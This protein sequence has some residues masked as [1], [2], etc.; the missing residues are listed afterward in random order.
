LCGLKPIFAELARLNL[1]SLTHVNLPPI[2]LST[3]Q[4]ALGDEVPGMAAGRSAPSGSGEV[5]A[6]TLRPAAAFAASLGFAALQLSVTAAGLRPRDLDRSARRDLAGMLRRSGL[7]LSGVD[8]FVPP[9]H[10]VLPAF[11]DRAVAALVAAA[12]TSRELADLCAGTPS[13]PRD[14]AS[15]GASVTFFAHPS[16]SAEVLTTIA[17]AGDRHGVRFAQA[18]W[19]MVPRAEIG[20]G[21]PSVGAQSV[22]QPGT[23]AGLAARFASALDPAALLAGGLDPAAELA[24][25][26]GYAVTPRLSDVSTV[27]RAVAG[28]SASSDAMLGGGRLDV[29]A[30]ATTMLACGIGGAMVLDLRGTGDNA[31]G[32]MLAMQALAEIAAGGGTAGGAGAAS[33]ASW[34][35]ARR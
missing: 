22:G 15:A 29:F 14:G 5:D 12:E 20:D 35:T 24:R 4:L 21:E 19:P 26:A 3:S 16:T 6:G 2:A 9:E 33:S 1:M 17:D 18:N 34:L 8:C 10:L 7:G 13:G 28:V 25:S 32:A 27:G 23:R 30:Y 11:V 31:R